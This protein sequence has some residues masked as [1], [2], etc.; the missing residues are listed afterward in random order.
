M[1]NEQ[2]PSSP[3]NTTPYAAKPI[4]PADLA[5]IKSKPEL[6][7]LP[8]DIGDTPSFLEPTLVVQT[9]LGVV[10]QVEKLYEAITSELPKFNWQRVI[11]MRDT[12]LALAH[13]E[14]VKR[15]GKR[16]VPSAIVAKAR[17]VRDLRLADAEPLVA[18]GLLPAEA[19]ANLRHGNSHRQLAIDL[20]GVANLFDQNY[21]ALEGKTLVTRED[22]QAA[23]E[24]AE[25]LLVHLGSKDYATD[26]DTE[27]N[28]E[29]AKLM[30]LLRAD[31]REVSWA[32]LY[33]RRNAGDGE[34]IVP[35]LRKIQMQRGSSRGNTEV[36]R[37]EEPQDAA[38]DI[39]SAADNTQG[40]P[41]AANGQGSAAKANT[42]A[43]KGQEVDTA[44]LDAM[45]SGTFKPKA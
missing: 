1:A 35:S 18:R 40:N 2:D 4:T 23:R 20:L 39:A 36:S 8:N 14:G 6:A 11:H 26:S 21:S 7:A 30:Y 38:A 31:Y 28:L 3:S 13:L 45:M 22:I 25:A 33:V 10:P 27:L 42:E 29:G 34:R 41:P 44:T 9:V 17:Q 43:A 15:Q 12:A 19:I 24:L 16:D 5:Y 32:V 37:D